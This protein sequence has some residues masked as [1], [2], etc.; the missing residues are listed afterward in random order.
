MAITHF[1][2]GASA[3]LLLYHITNLNSDELLITMLSGFWALIPDTGKLIEP[4][5]TLH[6]S[7]LANI[8]WFH[9]LIDTLE[10]G[11]PHVEGAIAITLL[12]SITIITRI[13]P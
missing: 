10:T 11:H 8:F 3:G 6:E 4:V 7:V 9:A 2:L 12:L 13:I 5:T 1:T